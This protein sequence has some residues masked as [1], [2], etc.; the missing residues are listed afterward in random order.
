MSKVIHRY[1]IDRTDDLGTSSFVR[2]DMPK[3]AKI[4][5]ITYV[6]GY[7]YLHAVVNPEHKKKERWFA[8]YTEGTPMEDY[9]KKTCEYIGM[10]STVPNFHVFEVHD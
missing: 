10:A 1:K 7:I 6:G 5:N 9:E 8:V 2:V 4:I 3:G